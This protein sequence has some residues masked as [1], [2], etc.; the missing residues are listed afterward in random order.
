M[1]SYYRCNKD[2]NNITEINKTY[3]H[4]MTCSYFSFWAYQMSKVRYC[5][6]ML[7]GAYLIVFSNI[8]IL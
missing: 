4:T 8:Y 3:V 7:L 1:L 5:L 6:I 2:I